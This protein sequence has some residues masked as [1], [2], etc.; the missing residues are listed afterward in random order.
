VPW[1]FSPLGIEKAP[2]FEGTGAGAGGRAAGDEKGAEETGEGTLE[3]SSGL[4]GA[5]ETEA[6]SGI[7]DCSSGALEGVLGDCED[8]FAGVVFRHIRIPPPQILRVRLRRAAGLSLGG[9]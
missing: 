1:I 3:V 4:D 9:I 7:F 6:A 5:G 2:E 8:G